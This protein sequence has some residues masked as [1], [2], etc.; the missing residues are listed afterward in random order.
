MLSQFVSAALVHWLGLAA[1]AALIGGLVLDVLILPQSLADLAAARRG[2]GRW[3]ALCTVVVMVAAA[4]DL[5]LRAQTM[6]R[7]SLA[8]AITSVPAVLAHTHFGTIWMAR[9][10]LLALLLA[11][12]LAPGRAPR[13]VATLL[14][15]AVALTT[16]LTGHAADW[17]ALTV[18]VVIDWVHLLAAAAWTGGLIGLARVVFGGRAGWPPELVG[19]IARR[20]S[21]LAGLCL[22]AVVLSG[23]GNAWVQLGAASAL[24]TTAYGRVLTVKLLMVLALVWIGA[25][26]RYAIVPY[27]GFG[28][29][30]R[31]VGVRLFRL[32][33]L[34]LFGRSRSMRWALPSRLRAYV[35]AEA[36]L[37]LGVFAGTAILGESTPGRH[38]GHLAHAEARGPFR[39]T[40]AELHARGGVPRG[41]S[42]RLPPG[43][44]IQGREI[45][46]KLECFACHT[47][48]GTGFPPPSEPGPDLTAIGDHHP[49]GYLAESIV[50]PNAVIVE[51][52]GYTGPDGTSIMPDY[53]ASLT[54]SELVDLVAY[55]TSLHREHR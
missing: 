36:L 23:A 50:N 3:T 25:I 17:G 18:S 51:G 12:S 33:R 30:A 40:M 54:V 45:F 28:R 31:G 21:R 42:F 44:E 13:V 8:V 35:A 11:V 38:A 29:P 43:D 39:A 14:A 2:L 24:W 16:S 26:N 15:L 22:L 47:V 53:G 52:P 1:L 55:L 5:V 4:V 34:A 10:A 19:T 49:S 46:A 9:I 48:R 27:C 20:F 32:A 6:S 37:A 41:W 7:A